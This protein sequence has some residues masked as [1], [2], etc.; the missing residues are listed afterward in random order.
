MK[1]NGSS[2]QAYS[3]NLCFSDIP[4]DERLTAMT[5]E[6]DN[7]IHLEDGQSAPIEALETRGYADA[8]IQKQNREILDGTVEA[9]RIERR[10]M[11]R[12]NYLVLPTIS[13]LY[14]F[15]YLDRGN[16]AVSR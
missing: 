16:V 13:A 2:S 12:L 6:K 8:S 11:W 10:Y 9:K 7:K 14:F 5:T 3:L 1:W 15:E 4:N